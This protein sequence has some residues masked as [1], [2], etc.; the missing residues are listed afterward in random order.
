MDTLPTKLFAVLSLGMLQRQLHGCALV[1][2]A[3]WYDKP[4]CREWKLIAVAGTWRGLALRPPRRCF[5]WKCL[6]TN[7]SKEHALVRLGNLLVAGKRYA[8]G[9]V[10]DAY[11]RLAG[12]GT[13]ATTPTTTPFPNKPAPHSRGQAQ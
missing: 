8:Y 3:V 6:K 2:S 1:R 7:A 12:Q 13:L 9:L 5:G 11:R 10:P 4:M